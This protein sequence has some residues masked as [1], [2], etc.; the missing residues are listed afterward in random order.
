MQRAR[1][2]SRIARNKRNGD[3][4]AA[5]PHRP[6]RLPQPPLRDPRDR[7]FRPRAPAH[8][9]P[10]HVGEHR[11]PRRGGREGRALDQGD[12][13]GPRRERREVLR[14]LPEPRRPRH[15]RVPRRQGERAPGRHEG[16]AGRHPLPQRHRGRR[17][18]D[19]R[20]DE[21]GRARAHAVALLPH[22]HLQRGQAR[23]LPAPA[24]PP[25]PRHG[26]APG[27]GGDREQ[28]PLQPAGRR[29][30]A[31]EP[32]Q[33]DGRGLPAQDARGNRRDRAQVRPLRDLRRNL[34]QH[35]TASS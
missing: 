20:P 13:R 33:P 3:R 35:R 23:R 27:P 10:D 4:H 2:K 21:E 9:P 34:L 8:G 29:D 5:S 19:L 12:R 32:R 18:Q 30:R 28:G 26:L 15:A 24:V 22:A 17:R 25:G 16:R 31:R 14:L 6:R 1:G 7:G 11:R